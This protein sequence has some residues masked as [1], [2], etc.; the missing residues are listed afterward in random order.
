M[1]RYL[2]ILLVALT[3]LPAASASNNWFYEYS[4]WVK[5]D[6]LNSNIPGAA[7]VYVQL[8]RPTVYANVGVTEAGGD[9]IN[10]DTVFRL[11]S[12]SKTFTG[13]LMAKLSQQNQLKL[14]KP[15]SQMAPGLAF[16]KSGN[17]DITL[18]HILNQSSGFIP[19]AY[20]NLIEANYSPT[21]VLKQLSELQ[22][23]CQPGQCYTYQNALFGVI[24]SYFFNQSSSYSKE[25]RKHLLLPLDMKNTSIGKQGLLASQTWAK[26]HVYISKTEFKQTKVKESYY[27]FSPAAGINASTHDIQIWLRAML[28]EYPEVLPPEVVRLISMPQTKTKRELNRKMWRSY[29]E[30]AHYGLGWRVYQFAGQK[31]VYHGGWVAGYRA[32]IAFAP[33]HGVGFAMLMNAESNRMNEYSVEFW[34]RFFAQPVGSNN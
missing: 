26:P 21:R 14:S 34:S 23:M 8:D 4:D 33:E 18:L 31:L 17:G 15:V 12:V 16:D 5:E 19:N 9:P 10:A 3:A 6:A 30:K 13:V 11:A 27:R 29:L 28:G 24:D 32:D 2:L 22:P 25:V 7:W 20:D 1:L